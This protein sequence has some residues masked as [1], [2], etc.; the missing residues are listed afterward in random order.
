[1]RSFGR[2]LLYTVRTEG[3]GATRESFAIGLGMFIGC[4]PA[5]GL[6]LG[7]CVAAGRMLGLNRLK[8]YLAANVSNPLMAPLLLFSELQVG[9]LLR[10]GQYHPISIETAR[11]ADIGTF[12][13]DLVLGSIAV[14]AILGLT[15]GLLTFVSVRQSSSDLAFLDLVRGASE[16][17]VAVSMTA[18]EFARGKLRSDAV[19]RLI[20]CGGGCREA[21]ACSIWGAGRA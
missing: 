13:G 11:T 16:R 21:N 14:G 4:L 2:Q 3:A 12:A 10:R 18:W 7:L 17:Y 5:Y 20:V 1:M 8:M 9:S 6:H 15:V 19:Y